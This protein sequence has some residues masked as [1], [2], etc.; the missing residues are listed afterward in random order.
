MAA[1]KAEAKSH[2]ASSS[3]AAEDLYALEEKHKFF[4]AKCGK[5]RREKKA[6]EA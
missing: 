5:L 6:S 1:A 4:K 2:K 3:K